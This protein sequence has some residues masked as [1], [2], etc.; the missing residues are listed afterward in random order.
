MRYPLYLL[1]LCMGALST[2]TSTTTLASD[3]LKERS[4]AEQIREQLIVGQALELSTEAAAAT[5]TEPA[6]APQTFFALY[7]PAEGTLKRGGVI[8]LHGLGAH[9]D[10]PD[11]IAPLRK[12]LPEAGW[13]TLSIQLPVW[14]NSANFEDYPPL[15]PAANRRISAAVA[16]LQQQG[17]A[18][19]TLVGHSLGAAMGAYFLAQK[20]PGSDAIRAFVGIGMNQ[21]PG[22]VA[23]TPDALANITIPVLDLYGAFDLDGVRDSA[24]ARAASQADNGGYRQTVIAGADHFFQG[25]DTTLIKRVAGWLTQ[26]ATDPAANDAPVKTRP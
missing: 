18:N 24:R 22:S 16:H 5:A 23:H 10:W 20:A 4:W 7:T 11:V 1:C 9:P 8:L 14:P 6:T 17:I 2:A 3:R 19:I 15:F 26:M 12:A 13:A 21:A 25:L